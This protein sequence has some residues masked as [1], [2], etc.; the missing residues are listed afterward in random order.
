MKIYQKR[1]NNISEESKNAL[2]NFR[3]N[4]INSN[5]KLHKLF[6]ILMMLINFGLISF[7]IFYKSKISQIKKLSNSHTSD[8]DSEDSQLVTQRTSLYNKMVNIAMAGFY[9]D[10]RFSFIFEKT[11][12]FQ[13]IKKIVYDYKAE[14]GEQLS[15]FDEIKTLFIY[16]GITDTDL[17]SAFIDKISYFENLV[18][19]IQTESGSKFGIY[20]RG[21]ITPNNKHNFDSDCKDVILFSLNN[22]KIYKFKGKKKSMHF[23]KYK[24]LSLGDD[25]LI[26]YNEYFVN[27]GYIDFP[28]KSFDFSTVNSNVLT[29]ENGKFKTR[30][31]EVYCFF[32]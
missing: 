10:F 6:L 3:Q 13:N 30:N 25:E 2:I 18:F 20:H 28:L 27:G 16:Q 11:D 26:I 4:Q 8:I 22:N 15:N 12:E 21:L 5:I 24:F 23:N 19:I 9:G 1:S 32:G 29:N 17:Y 14:I 31:I 7:I